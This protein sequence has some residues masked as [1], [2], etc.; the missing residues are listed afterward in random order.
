[1]KIISKDYWGKAFTRFIGQFGF[2][3]IPSGLGGIS[4]GGILG[5]SNLGNKRKQL[6]AYQSHVYKCVTLIY[7]RAISVPMKL[8]KER[9]D[10]DEEIKRHPFIDLMKRPNP[11]MTGSDLKAITIMHRDLAGMGFWYIVFN[12]LGRPAELWPLPVGNFSQFVFN[13]SKTELL[14]YEFKTDEG[15]PVRYEPDEIVYFRY[16]HPL[17]FLEG[18]SPVQAMAFAYDTDM[19]IRTYQRRFFQNSARAD[20]VF[21]SDQNIQ[22]DDAKRLLLAWK[23]NHQG[24]NK[25]WE[26]AILDNGL[27]VN[28]SLSVTAK[29][30]EFAELAGWTK[31]DILEAYNVPEGKLGSVKDVNRANALGIDITFN[32]ECIKPRLD[33]FE[34][35][36]TLSLL[37]YYDQ[38]LYVEHVNC[39]PRDLEHDLK[40]RESNLKSK[41]TTINEERA[42]ENMDPVPW[43]DKPFVTINEI[44]W[45][46]SLEIIQDSQGARRTAQG[47]R[48]TKDIETKDARDQ[49][50]QAHERRIAARSRV[51][52]TFLRKFFKAQQK[53]VLDNLEEN[54][55]RIEGVTSGMSLKKVKDWLKTNKDQIDRI[56]FDMSVAN[57]KLVDGSGPYM[58][59]TLLDAGEISLAEVGAADVIFDTM[60]SQALDHLRGKNIILQDV[61]RVTHDMIRNELTAGFEAGETMQQMAGRI[62]KV[63]TNADQVRS[64]RIAQTETNSTANFGSLEGYRQSGVVEKKE[65]LAG[66]DAR[67]THAEAAGRYSGDGAIML[68]EDFKVGEGSGPAPGNI[69]RPEEDIN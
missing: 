37:P 41:F 38:G 49:Y 44:Q 47:V 61:N 67:E 7:R 8:Y 23:Q 16:P 58:Q 53:E 2:V 51:Y 59:A 36:I 21:E 62:R 42:K 60:S 40:E 27:K 66:S 25:S 14:A 18:A 17:Y 9:G 4:G 31:E 65:W 30:F 11:L 13:D 24:V 43:G 52:R 10:D 33:S 1:M 64:L 39:I 20:V 35:Q 34:E 26:P 48:E 54:F 68:H 45:G 12:S 46:E 69:G 50:R 6:E 63:F 3:K 55:K 32:S 15:R 19:A 29:D 22:P 56:S 5:F 28:N 57:K